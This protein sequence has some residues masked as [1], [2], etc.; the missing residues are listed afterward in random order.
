MAKDANGRE[1]LSAGAIAKELQ[2]TPAAVKKAL[3]SMKIDADFVK[4]GCA[5]YYR[6]RVAKVQRALE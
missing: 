6:E 4:S 3:Q 5:Y 2:A 1:G